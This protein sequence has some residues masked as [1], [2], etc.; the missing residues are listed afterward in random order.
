MEASYADGT[1]IHCEQ[2]FHHPPIQHFYMVGPM[3]AYKMYGYAKMRVSASMNSI[4]VYN[5]GKK[6]IEFAD[7]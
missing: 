2:T 4:S 3:N 7:G 1:Q 6:W 5:D